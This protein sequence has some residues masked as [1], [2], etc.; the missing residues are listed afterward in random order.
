MIEPKTWSKGEIIDLMLNSIR[1]VGKQCD[2]LG[3]TYRIEDAID[4]VYED[5]DDAG[6]IEHTP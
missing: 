4:Q 1:E 2:A 3:Q 5:L 6:L